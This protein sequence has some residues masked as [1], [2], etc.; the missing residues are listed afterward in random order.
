MNRPH[1]IAHRGDTVNFPE[2]TIEAFASAFDK[3]ADGVEMDVYLHENDEV[4]VVHPWL[5]D[6]SKTY[7][8]LSEVIEQ[9]AKRG[10]LEIELKSFDLRCIEKVAELIRQYEVTNYEITSSILP[11]LSYVK[12]VLPEAKTGMIF[13]PYHLEDWMTPTV[14]LDYLSGYMELARCDVL[15]LNLELYTPELVMELHKRNYILHTH[16][17]SADSEIFNK[18]KELGLDQCTFDDIAILKLT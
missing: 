14:V 9:F 16:L 12:D 7:P 6:R 18:V 10:T 3:G 4:V 11:L 13:K 2:N 8:L 1:L 17:K 15:H 5:H